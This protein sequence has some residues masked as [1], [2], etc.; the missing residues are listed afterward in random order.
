MRL[1]HRAAAVLCWSLVAC[2]AVQDDSSTT[3]SDVERSRFGSSKHS[4]TLTERIAACEADPRVIAGLSGV[5]VCVGADLFFRE[6][7]GGNG[8]SCATCHPAENNFT[9]DPAFVATLPPTDPLFVASTNANLAGLERPEV[10]LQRALVL[11]NADGF[12]P[13][14]TVRFVLR[15][16]P[17]NLSMDTSVA[18]P[19]GQAA[20]PFDRTGW[21]ADGAPGEGRLRDFQTGAV[22]QHYP[23]TLARQAG[24]DFRLPTSDELDRM[25]LYM[26]RLGRTSE[27]DLTAV[28]LTDPGA[29]TGR[30]LFINPAV[31]CNACHQN[32]G[33]NASI[34]T[35]GNRNF[36]TGVESA[37]N[38]ALASFPKDGGFRASPLNPDGSFG[39]GTFNTPPLIEAADTGPFFHTDTTIDGASAH[40]TGTATTIEQAIA[41]YDSP[42][43]AN[44]PAGAAGVIALTGQEIDNL[45][46][47][48]RAL[49]ASF[50]AQLALSRLSGSL[51]L[52]DQFANEH[53]AIQRGLIRFAGEEID[54]ATSVLGAVPNLNVKSMQRLQNAR[55][56]IDNAMSAP[57]AASRRAQ[58]RQ[59]IDRVTDAQRG[60]GTGLELDIGEGTL[61]F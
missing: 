33:A 29:E 31:R 18:L 30:A 17:H 36:N 3:G 27:L 9:I 7:F 8:R 42:A 53:L 49:N 60:L 24:T 16:V 32:A 56:H 11:E 46:R 23:Q 10:L 6:T 13:D 12:E 22:I 26:R 54:D 2:G 4:L 38:A 52:V 50:N 1:Q 21:S 41:F 25:D 34:S 35:G 61:M 39:D 51:T 15:S 20:P 47:F 58:L 44:S 55:T 40:D 14:P 43:F 28:S 5:D 37:R 57:N 59:A 19:P 45:G 48:L